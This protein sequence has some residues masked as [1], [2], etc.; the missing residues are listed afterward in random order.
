M[1]NI[2]MN[3][4]NILVPSPVRAKHAE[5][6]GEEERRV[7]LKYSLIRG[8]YWSRLINQRELRI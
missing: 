1:A 7:K 6:D 2:V 4:I 5:E 8:E 3:N